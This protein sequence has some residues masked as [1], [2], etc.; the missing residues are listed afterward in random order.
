MRITAVVVSLCA[1]SLFSACGDS[2]NGTA[3][4]V[5]GGSANGV[6]SIVPVDQFSMANGCYAIQSVAT[7]KHVAQSG[8]AYV[9]N[10]ALSAA[11]AFYMKPSALGKYLIYARDRS[12]VSAS[13]TA[14][15]SPT[16]RT[17]PSASGGRTKSGCTGANP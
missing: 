4:N 14:I 1:A 7:G 8:T 16:K 10:A 2:T 15:G 6:G 13:T 5:V 3:S 17:L 11:E 12:L 9:A